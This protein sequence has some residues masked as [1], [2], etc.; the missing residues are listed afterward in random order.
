MG[1]GCRRRKLA[2]VR[3]RERSERT[4]TGPYPVIGR[5]WTARSS[6]DRPSPNLPKI[7]TI[8]ASTSLREFQGLEACEHLGG[9]DEN[10][11]GPRRDMS[12]KVRNSLQVR[13][14][15]PNLFCINRRKDSAPRLRVGLTCG[16]PTAFVRRWI[17]REDC[18]DGR[19]ANFADDRTLAIISLAYDLGADSGLL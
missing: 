13:R 17:S 11:R 12:C 10:P 4:P 16:T 15:N 14:Q 2:R 19:A 1:L 6:F 8:Y 9:S 3:L 18:A 5:T 7:I